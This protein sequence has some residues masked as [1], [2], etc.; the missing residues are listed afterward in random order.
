MIKDMPIDFTAVIFSLK[1]Q[2][3]TTVKMI[4]FAA[5]PTGYTKFKLNVFSDLK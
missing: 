5:T 4:V 3:A 1:S 2:Y